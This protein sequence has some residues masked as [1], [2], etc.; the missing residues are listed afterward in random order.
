[1]TATGGRSPGES[2]PSLVESALPILAMLVLFA[3]TALFLDFGTELLV[4]I[5]VCAAA[6]AGLIARR[7][8]HGWDEV[9]S[10]MG[11]RIADAMPALVILLA[12]GLLIGA[13][14]LSGT[15]PY[16][17]YWGVRLISPR[18]L[19]LTAFLATAAMSL[20]TGTSWGSAGTIGVALVGTAAALGA[21]V[22]AT[23]GAVVSGAYFG[24]KMS[25]LSDMTNIAA[26]GAGSELFDHIRH[27]VWTAGPSFVACLAVYFLAG[28]GGTGTA[29][30]AADAE[31]FLAGL[32]AAFSLS[33]LVLLPPVVVV[34]A[35]ARRVPAAPGIALSS[36]V[37]ISL[38]VALQGFGLQDA[39]VAAVAGFEPG[40]LADRG[41]DP[42]AMDPRVIALVD[43]GGIFSMATTLVIVFAA[44]L[45][46][47]AMEAYGALDR[48]IRA[49][50]GTVRGV[51][52]LIAATM[53]AGGTMIG[54][55]SHGGVTA[56][57]VGGL[58]QPAYDER[59]L[60]RV[61]LSRSIE[62]SV[63]LTEPLMPW[64]VSAVF[65]A[66]TLGV[67]TTAYLPWAVFNYGGP[68]FSLLIAAT[69]G[70]TGLGIR[71]R[72]SGADAQG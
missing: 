19:L 7:R 4:V 35:I 29:S 30:R 14:V 5:L 47:G 61:N 28:T 51:F 56:L 66:G 11:Q 55:T 6:V 48:L 59:G 50:L 72:T 69:Y 10:A 26:I 40:L 71:P 44:F 60:A 8:G 49:L 34:W 65:M 64:T 57:V 31:G 41:L 23:A 24:D 42:D 27:M 38:G 9:Q 16:M 15:I 70:R 43:R 46:A 45:L 22:E 37:A 68:I 62:D 21:P 20:F 54:L 2:D 33:P 32:D 67:A 39:L 1:V 25:P 13:W 58:F 53:A 12:I 3:G 18:F 63:T 17:V 36:A 52:G